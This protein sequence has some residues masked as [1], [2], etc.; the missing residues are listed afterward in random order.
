RF[1]DVTDIIPAGLANYSFAED[2]GI[3]QGD[4]IPESSFGGASCSS[5]TAAVTAAAVSCNCTGSCPSLGTA[6]V[7]AFNNI[8][9]RMQQFMPELQADQVR[10][11]Y[12]F[13]GLGYAGDPNGIDVA[14]LVKVSLRQEEANRPSFQPIT[15]L[16]FGAAIPL[17]PFSAELTL[18]D[19]LDPTTPN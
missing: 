17:P 16:L 5:R 11:D 19:G 12:A 10:I 14:P 9:A 8:L 13:S 15:L 3:P 18:E 6:S 4:P 1:A 2:G 7:A